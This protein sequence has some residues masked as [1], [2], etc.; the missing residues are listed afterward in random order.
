MRP[1]VP[2]SLLFAPRAQARAAIAPGRSG[3]CAVAD[4]SEALARTAL[5]GEKMM[6][7][8]HFTE[9]QIVALLEEAET[10]ADIQDIC[11]QHEISL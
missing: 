3:A 7:E 11:R 9:E 2:P 10:G 4:G 1:P 6:K 5:R 8:S